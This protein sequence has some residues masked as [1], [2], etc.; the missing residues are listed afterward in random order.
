L[1][2]AWFTPFS[3]TSGIGK[4]GA[5]FIHELQKGH[6]ITV[7]ADGTDSLKDVWLTDIPLHLLRKMQTVDVVQMLPAFDVVFYNMGDA[8]HN[9]SH[10]YDTSRAYPGI[11]ILHDL[12]MHHFF[13]NYNLIDRQDNAGFIRELTFSH[14]KAGNELG[15]KIVNGTSGNIWTTSQMLTFNMALS[16][17][18]GAHGVITHSPYSQ[19]ILRDIAPAPVAYVPFPTPPSIEKSASS[20]LKDSTRTCLFSF[21]VINPNKMIAEVIEAIGTSSFLKANVTYN[22]LGTGESAYMEHLNALVKNHKLEKY[23]QFLGYQPDDVLYQAIADADIIINIRNP[24]FGESSASLI[25]G[26]SMGKP[27]VVWNHGYYATFPDETVVK[28]NS[29]DS[30]VNI[31]SQL[32]KDKNLRLTYGQAARKYIEDHLVTA[33]STRQIIAFAEEVRKD[34]LVFAVTDFIIREMQQMGADERFSHLSDTIIETLSEL[35][36]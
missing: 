33:E 16:A 28:V 22:I 36:V 32:V 26:M 29:Q 8:A 15:E 6:D 24:H 4:Y 2:I 14:G 20:T 21:G 34:R 9:H 23:V 10:I 11:V 13:Y 1:K 19:Q 31:L 7:F 18:R 27:T 25:E 12:V 35:I 30:F 17:I 5:V 3:K